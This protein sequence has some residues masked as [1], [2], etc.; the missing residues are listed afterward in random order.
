MK[1]TTNTK[2][3]RLKRELQRTFLPSS[4]NGRLSLTLLIVAL[5]CLL[6]FGTAAYRAV[7]TI[8]RNRMQTAIMTDAGQLGDRMRAEYLSLVHVSQQMLPTGV[9]GNAV[10]DYLY[11][12]SAYER[13]VSQQLVY[14]NLNLAIFSLPNAEL[15]AYYDKEE[16]SGIWLKN[17]V[18]ND[19]F[20]PLEIPVLSQT[21][22]I[23][24]NAMH[25]TG[26][27]FSNTT[28][29]SIVR[30]VEFS[31][32]KSRYIY[33]EC[34]T[35]ILG[36]ITDMSELQGMP[37]SLL[38]VDS[39]GVIAYSTLESY[40]AG[41]S[42]DF[43]AAFPDNE[44]MGRSEGFVWC[45]AEESFGFTNVLLV[46]SRLY[47]LEMNNL[48]RDLVVYT[49]LVIALILFLTL[50]FRKQF[51]APLKYLEHE[52]KDFAR[53]D[54]AIKEYDYKLDEYQSL[55]RQFSK[56]KTQITGLMDDIYVKEKEKRQLE[57]DKLYFQINPHFMMNAL[58]SAQWQA[59]MEDQPELASYLY[60][61]N[62][63]LGY[64][65]GKVNQNTTLYSEIQVLTSYLELQQTRQDFQFYIDVEE[66]LYLEHEC[67]RLI[68]QPIAENAI[69]H[70]LDDFGNLWVTV[71]ELHTGDVRITIRDDGPGFDV[72][73]LS[74]KDPPER[75][76]E[77]QTQNGIGLRYVWLTL[78]SFYHG[79]A[80]M[81]IESKKGSG[82]TVE[83]L[84]SKI[85]EEEQ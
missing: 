20:D 3:G 43:D 54:R 66:G 42:F 14:E 82:T 33:V 64:T 19:D 9:V 7:S 27:R 68:L 57:L 21:S 58:N 53:G 34:K 59:T 75:G 16:N 24:F 77:R 15:V 83:I 52:M 78:Q 48:I 11:A 55:F 2:S 56:M 45:R 12:D 67:A 23:S 62:F 18:A 76:T 70:S 10:E 28:V 69:C 13:Y 80:V 38:Q 17:L 8:E 79:K 63:L 37:Y 74:F 5:L 84:L 32:D 51:Y 73:T 81:E 22:D 72:A 6:M 71:R 60:H 47:D 36:S 41:T 39:G 44:S 26:N 35:D 29:I 85:T 65:L 49:V 46:P 40:P 61:L 25:R 50:T 31:D 1:K 4:L 30:E